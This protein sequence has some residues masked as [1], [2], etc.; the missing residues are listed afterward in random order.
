MNEK[1]TLAAQIYDITLP[2]INGQVGAEGIDLNIL[3]NFKNI[4]DAFLRMLGTAEFDASEMALG[5]YL[6]AKDQGD[7][8]FEAIPIFL[9]RHFPHENFYVKKGS[10]LNSPKDLAGKSLCM[11]SF[12]NTRS[13]WARGIIEDHY[14]VPR[15]QI[16][17]FV[18]NPDRVEVKLAP[19]IDVERLPQGTTALDALEAGTIDA[20][21]LL[22]ILSKVLSS[23]QIR[24]LFENHKKEEMTYYQK[25][26]IFPGM[27]TVV[28]KKEILDRSPWVA[29]SLMKAYQESKEACYD[30]RSRLAEFGGSSMVWMYEGI[31]EQSELFQQ[32]PY[33][34][35]VGPNKNMLE[36][37][38]GYLL[39]EGMISKIPDISSLFSKSTTSIYA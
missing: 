21:I 11:P 1:I 14:G 38:A 18:Q 39:K 31:K 22:P 2:L 35:G 32:D 10:S 16:K 36:V 25:T 17:W 12:Q 24:P 13:V 23:R 7:E 3:T 26:K 4:N 9:N 28:I 29:N 27:H 5:S 20:M 37:L 34:F 15:T 8:R 6:V 19:G 33:Q 30:L